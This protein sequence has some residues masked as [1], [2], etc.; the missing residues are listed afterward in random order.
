MFHMIHV[1]FIQDTCYDIYLQI[2]LFWTNDV[3]NCKTAFTQI[4][5]LGTSTYCLKQGVYFMRLHTEGREVLYNDVFCTPPSGVREEPN[6]G[7][8]I[9]FK[10]EEETEEETEENLGTGNGETSGAEYEE[11]S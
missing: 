8:E 3:G 4:S 7:E 11:N 2:Q 9:D 6:V 1:K 5:C 10:C